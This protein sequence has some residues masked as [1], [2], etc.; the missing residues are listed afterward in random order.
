MSK[1]PKYHVRAGGVPRRR[2]VLFPVPNS[3]CSNHL[4]TMKP[5]IGAPMVTNATMQEWTCRKEILLSQK[6]IS[7]L[8]QG[9]ASTKNSGNRSSLKGTVRLVPFFYIILGMKEYQYHRL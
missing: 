9:K 4:T 3:I 5:N 2:T 1:I 7:T 8:R 6:Y